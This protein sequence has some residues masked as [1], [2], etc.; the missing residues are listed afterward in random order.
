MSN[1]NPYAYTSPNQPPGMAMTPA[2]GAPQPWE[3]GEVI[4]HAWAMFKPHWPTLVFTQ[5]LTGILGGIP[6]YVPGVMLATHSVE[7]HSSAYWTIYGVCMSLAILLNAFFSGGMIKVWLSATRGQAPQF[8]D[9]FSG[10]GRFLPILAVLLLTIL[11]VG[12]GYVLLVVPGIILALGLSFSQF[13]VVDQK[14]GPIDAM[15]ASWK[16]TSGHKGKIFL[17][18]LV[19]LLLFIGGYLACCIG[20]F[21]AL[22]IVMVAWATIYTRITGTVGNAMQPPPP[23]GGTGYGPGGYNPPSGYGPPGTPGGPGYGP[24]PA[25]GFGGPPGYGPPGGGY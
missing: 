12:L 20:V 8:S 25:G 9:M 4:S 19:A 6:N 21:V 1:Y 14:L 2:A 11:G 15:K 13:F 18:G 23:P 16:A 10:M 17:F 24:P 5:L 3:I 7:P 22:P